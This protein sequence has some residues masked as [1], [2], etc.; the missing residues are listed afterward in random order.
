MALPPPPTYA[1]VVLHDKDGSNPRFNPIWL[2]WFLE[3]TRNLGT[4]GYTGTITTA[5][6]T[7]LGANGSMTFTNGVLVSQVAAT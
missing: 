7:A 6:L 3:L 4:T 5:K 2:N 1:E